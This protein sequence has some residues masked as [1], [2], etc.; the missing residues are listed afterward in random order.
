MKK[1]LWIFTLI[2]LVSCSNHNSEIIPLDIS[3]LMPDTSDGLTINESRE[4][5]ER[6]YTMMIENTVNRK[7]PEIYVYDTLNQPVK[8]KSMLD[9]KNIIISADAY[10][11]FGKESMMKDFPEA[12]EKYRTQHSD[13]D[14]NV[15][16]L[17]KES[18]EDKQNPDQFSDFVDDLKSKYS[19]LYIIKNEEAH[20]L[21]L[22][23]NPVRLYVNEDFVVK[24]FDVGL[25]LVEGNLYNEIETNLY[26]LS[27]NK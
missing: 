14:L 7:I 16:C 20:K 17:A 5:S 25:S 10:C 4:H 12:I 15:I 6:I 1:Y 22:H 9:N 24:H 11:G 18:P 3:A 21:N 27:N 26:H 2:Y 19:N 8:L 23:A 13:I